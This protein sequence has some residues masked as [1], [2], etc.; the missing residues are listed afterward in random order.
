MIVFASDRD[1][2]S[3]LYRINPDGSGLTQLT[4]NEFDDTS[5]AWSPDG[6]RIAF[7][8]DRDGEPG[9]YAMD[10]D[11]TDV[12]RI[13]E[14][15]GAEASRI[16]WSPDGKRIAFDATIGSDLDIWVCNIDG[17][18]LKK[19]A[20]DAMWPAWSPDGKTIAF[21]RGQLPQLGVMDSDGGNQRMLLK[22]P[23]DMFPDL[24]PIWSPDGK[25]IL[26][27]AVTGV[28]RDDAG[29]QEM[30]YEIRSVSSAG[31]DVRPI[32]KL[33]G[34]ALCWSPDGKKILLTKMSGEE[35]DLHI[36]TIG[37]EQSSPLAAGK[38]KEIFASWTAR[39][40]RDQ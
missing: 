32:M 22:D 25:R 38:G 10:A 35:I 2:D 26:Y 31:D 9:V 1:G 6:T 17:S 11:G 40:P 33:N 21:N 7:V 20:K 12:V 27:T 14:G 5:P 13:A 3:E 8:S 28:A 19:I 15:G 37:E 36:L 39:G 23:G 24:G 4:E 18:D 16:T 34:M 30:T 29:K